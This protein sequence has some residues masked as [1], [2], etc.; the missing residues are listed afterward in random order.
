MELEKDVQTAASLGKALLERHEKSLHE[1]TQE[2]SKLRHAVEELEGRN[3]NLEMENHDLEVENQKTIEENR[4]LLVQLEGYNQGM[5]M[6]EIKVREMQG[7]LD[8]LHVRSFRP[9]WYPL[10][11]RN[12]VGTILTQE[13]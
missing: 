3:A 2:R 10:R 12:I 13:W 6:N 9:L 4:R 8:A 5:S 7:D 1:G 11:L